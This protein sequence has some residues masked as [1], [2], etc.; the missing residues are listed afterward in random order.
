MPDMFDVFIVGTTGLYLSNYSNST[1]HLDIDF[2]NFV[3]GRWN[4]QDNM[5]VYG[6]VGYGS[7]VGAIGIS[8]K[9]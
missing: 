4:F 1:S 6:L 8:F 3:G 5:S 2:G 7:S 9:F